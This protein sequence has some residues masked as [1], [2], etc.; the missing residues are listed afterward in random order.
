MFVLDLSGLGAQIDESVQRSLAPLDNLGSEI[1][2]QMAPLDDL[3]PQIE[4]RVRASLAPM[5]ADLSNLGSQ[6]SQQVEQSLLPV[7]A[8]AMRLQ[9]VNGIGGKTIVN[10]PNGKTLLAKDG[11]LYECSGTI[12]KEGVC[13]GNL[14]PLNLNKT[15]NYCYLTP[16]VRINNYF[17]FS[18]GNHGVSVSDINGKITSITST[19]NTPTFLISQEDFQKM[20]KFSGS[21]T[22]TY[23]ADVNNPLSIK[24]PNKNPYL[25]CQNNT[26]NVCIFT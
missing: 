2:K 8:M 12:S 10:F 21:K 11:D 25:K 13:D 9:M 22:Y 17:C 20:C 26:P 3:G 6:I 16:N 4:N 19:D 23:L 5:Q 18:S 1:R 14:S 15:E 7:K 24:I